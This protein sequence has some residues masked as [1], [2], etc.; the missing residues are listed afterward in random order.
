MRR[1]R[2]GA[3]AAG[4]GLAVVYVMTALWVGRTNPVLRFPILDGFGPAPPYRW[5]SPPPSLASTNQPPR[6]GR[7]HVDLNP[8]TGSEARVLSTRDNQASLVLDIG[9]IPPRQGATG[10]L[11]TVTPTAPT[12]FPQPSGGLTVTGNVYRI[13]ATYQPGGQ[14]IPRLAKPGQVVLFYPAGAGNVIHKHRLLVSA[15]GKS[16]TAVPAA[17][18]AVQ[19]LIQATVSSLGYFAVGQATVGTARGRSLGSLVVYVIVAVLIAPV[20]FVIVRT[21]LRLRRRRT[22]RPPTRTTGRRPRP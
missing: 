1:R 11:I 21:E 15:D 4:A 12:G 10:A 19:Q 18:A 7:F 8:Q 2:L 22:A 16:W 3:I 6:S 13:V 14:S 9:S 20:V 17:D 5:V